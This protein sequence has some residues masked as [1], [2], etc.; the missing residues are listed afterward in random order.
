MKPLDYDTVKDFW[1]HALW[2][3]KKLRRGEIWVAKFCCGGYMKH[4]F[5]Q[6]LEWYTK[7]TRGQDYDTWYRGRFLEK[8]A[9][10]LILT[11]LRKTFAPYDEEG[12]KEALYHTTSLFQQLPQETAQK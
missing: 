10:P 3:A 11:E 6:C 2:T 7:A 1:Y 9:D 8:W 5:L 4:R 12:V